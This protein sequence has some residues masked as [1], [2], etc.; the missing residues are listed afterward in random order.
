[1]IEIGLYRLDGGDQM[2]N[3]CHASVQARRPA[4]LV[5]SGKNARVRADRL[6]DRV[7][8]HHTREVTAV[9]AM[10][11]SSVDNYGSRKGRKNAAQGAN[12]G[13]AEE[14]VALTTED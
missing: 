7:F 1:M 4:E 5:L 12:P 8:S 6:Q 10:R 13:S 3:G 11:Q 2:S 14:L 9:T